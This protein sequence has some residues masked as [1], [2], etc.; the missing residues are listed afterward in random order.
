MKK[1]MILVGALLVLS[2]GLLACSSTRQVSR[3]ITYEEFMKDQH[4]SWVADADVG[5]TVVVTL[6]SNPT[7]GFKWPDIAQIGNQEI[8]KQTDHRYVSPQQ[9]G[10][11]GASGKDTWTF[12]ALKKGTTIISM[13]YSRPWESGAKVEWTFVATITVQ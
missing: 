12:K 9:T 1:A 2:L 8:L 11:L 7:T 3:E 10:V 6:G 13:D 5:E 4:F